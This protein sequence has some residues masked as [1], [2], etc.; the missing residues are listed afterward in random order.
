MKT[1]KTKRS[2]G[3]KV[4]T[5]PWPKGVTAR[6]KDTVKNR[7]VGCG[8]LIAVGHNLCGE[9]ACEDDSGY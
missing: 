7:C 9:C 6:K 4:K 1:A 2:A 8:C 3:V 5:T